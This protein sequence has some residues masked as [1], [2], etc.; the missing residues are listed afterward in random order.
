[1][2]VN[3]PNLAALRTG[4]SVAMQRG[5]TQAAPSQ[6]S[7]I[8]SRV[9]STQKEQKYGWLGKLPNVREWIGDRVVQNISESDYAIKE[10]KWELTIG[11][12]RDDIETDNLG[13]YSL[14]F[15]QLGESTRSKPE[16][17]VWDLLKAGFSTNCYDGQY[18]F[19]TDHPVLDANGVPQSV[20]NTDGGSGTPWFLLD[21]SRV[22]KPLLLQVRRD[23]GKLVSKDKDTDDNVFDRNEFVYGVDARLNVGYG[24]WQM[25]WGSKQTLNADNYK[26][27][28][29]AIGSMKGDYGRPLGLSGKL[30]VVPPT[31]ESAGLKLL[32]NELGSGGETNEWKSTAELL[33]VPWLA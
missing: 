19:D 5:Q 22:I 2:E 31:L 10:K 13:H 18:F 32:N 30:L 17:L 9:P 12:D 29:A 6:A 25:A 26:I 28:R 23:F 8:A 1:M 7:R 4:Y 15:E 24:F 16:Q 33:V 27:A 21:T 14:L 20:A 3:N 11:V